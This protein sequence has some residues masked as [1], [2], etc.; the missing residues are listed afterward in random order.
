MKSLFLRTE[1]YTMLSILPHSS[2]ICAHVAQR[3]LH[4]VFKVLIHAFGVTHVPIFTIDDRDPLV[5]CEALVTDRTAGLG[6]SLLV[7]LI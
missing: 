2:I 1:I 5:R 4:T 6:P 3:A 7:I